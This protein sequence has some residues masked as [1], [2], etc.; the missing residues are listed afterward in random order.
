MKKI[1]V[2]FL[3][4]WCAI[5]SAQAEEVLRE[6]EG[7]L[8]LQV[9]V[10]STWGAYPSGVWVKN[11]STG[12]S[13]GDFSHTLLKT[14]LPE[15]MYCVDQ[16]NIATRGI[17]DLLYCKPP[18]FKVVAGRLNNAGLWTFE[19][20]HDLGVI[21]LLGSFANLDQTLRNIKA[22]YPEDFQ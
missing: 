15:G 10:K 4:L 17:E 5:Y 2:L 7:F 14:K 20:D 19:I 18:Y 16:I 12:K 1:A 3:A 6:G 9:S 8:I 21:N 11:L 13:Y 22:K